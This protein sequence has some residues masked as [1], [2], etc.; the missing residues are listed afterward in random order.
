MNTIKEYATAHGYPYV[1]YYHLLVDK[2]GNYVSS[3]F[4]DGV[5][6]T[7]STYYIMEDYVK[8][9]IDAELSK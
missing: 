7:L 3:Y 1:D 2:D 8:P 5:H 6:P 4:S 9:I